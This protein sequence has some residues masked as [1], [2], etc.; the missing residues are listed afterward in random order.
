MFLLFEE[1]SFHKFH[2]D[3]VESWHDDLVVLGFTVD[4]ELADCVGPVDPLFLFG[5]EL[6]VVARTLVRHLELILFAHEVA[7]L[8]IEFGATFRCRCAADSPDQAENED[9]FKHLL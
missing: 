5:A 9:A 4:G 1:G 6:V 3:R 2:S 7:D 8:N